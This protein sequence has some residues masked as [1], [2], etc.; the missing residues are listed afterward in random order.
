MT[1]MKFVRMLIL[2]LGLVTLATASSFAAMPFLTTSTTN[3][4][5]INAQTGLAGSV[6]YTPLIAGTVNAGEIVNLAYQAQISFLADITV[7]VK[8]ECFGA[9]TGCIRPTL[10]ATATAFADYGTTATSSTS[11]VS[12][13][14]NQTSILISFANV[15]GFATS[16]TIRIDGVRLDVSTMATAGGLTTVALSNTTGQA[17]ASSSVLT[18]GTFSEPLTVPT[19]VGVNTTTNALN[20]YSNATV[21][22]GQ[23]LV[24][25]SLNEVFSNAFESKATSAFGA[26]YANTRIKITLSNIPSG[27]AITGVTLAGVNGATFANGQYPSFGVQGAITTNPL[28]VSIS[29]QNANALQGLQVGITFGV[30]SGTTSL[31]LSP[32]PIGITATLNQAAPTIGSAYPGAGGPDY[33]FN[34]P[35]YQL[36]YFYQSQLKFVER[37]VAAS[38][39]V[40]ITPLQTNLLSIFN[41]AIREPAQADQFIYDTG[42]SISNTSG[43]GS[44]P[45]GLAGTITVTLYAHDGTT[46]FF[47]T[48]S[49]SV[50]R[51][52]IGL[53]NAGTLGPKQS[54]IVLLSQLLTPAGY[55]STADFRGFIRFQCN[56]QGGL[57]INYLADGDF[58][59]NGVSQGYVMV[60]DVPGVPAASTATGAGAYF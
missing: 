60:S 47:T 24:T 16:D 21:N 34:S 41:M 30:T 5:A 26:V 43:T 7:T 32:A 36:N 27:M 45:S 13:T 48:G 17:T 40:T 52:G 57:G 49:D 15:I 9:G 25:V 6:L 39:P 31:A 37:T 8:G 19:V 14:V 35:K 20:F 1:S 18:V 59:V 10:P 38:I 53:S 46:K 22:G 54:W 4:I 11:G 56:F 55:S 51:P 44:I 23:N 42:F 58:S 2:A 28:M 3:I 33:P 50:K 29:T 12:V